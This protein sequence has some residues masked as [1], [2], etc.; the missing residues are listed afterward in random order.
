MCRGGLIDR[1]GDA[2]QDIRMEKASSLQVAVAGVAFEL[3]P[4][5]TAWAPALGLLVVSD[6]HLE[7]GS[8]YA[9]R[10][11]MLPPYDSAETLAR[12]VA[13]MEALRPQKVISLGDSFHDRGARGRMDAGVVETLRAMT[14]VTD[15]VW[16]CGNH[17]VAPPDDLGG[18]IAQEEAEGALVFRHEPVEGPV[19]GE[20]AGHLHPCARVGGRVRSVRA[21]CFA[22]NGER[23][24]M[25]SFGALTGGLNVR[26]EAFAPLFPDGLSACV[27]GRDAVY[28]VAGDRLV[29]DR[30]GSSRMAG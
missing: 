4:A 30:A 29:A 18:R 13:E 2:R 7:K 28:A 14:S 16:I 23:L 17:D 25:P 3:R 9:V 15:W 10:G 21:K 11:Q 26:D 6:L 1:L 5:C 27:V 20:V 19:I 24:V 22:T 8:A 12:L